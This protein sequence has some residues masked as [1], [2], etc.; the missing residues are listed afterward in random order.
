MNKNNNLIIIG[1]VILFLISVI[2][3]N[4]GGPSDQPVVT[5]QIPTIIQT[6]EGKVTTPVTTQ[7]TVQDNK[8][9]TSALTPEFI[10]PY[11]FYDP[12]Y[13]YGGYYSSPP[14]NYYNWYDD[15]R[16][17]P[18]HKHIPHHQYMGG[19][20]SHHPAAISRMQPGMPGTSPHMGTR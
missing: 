19:M 8:T 2:L 9:L 12:M 6:V 7:E 18:G 10:D 3:Y 13:W 17:R 5:T 20:Q 15:T 11:Y 4:A 1:L 14:H 16:Y